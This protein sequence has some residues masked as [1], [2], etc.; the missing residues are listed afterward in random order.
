LGTA[1]VLSTVL[2]A[3]GA[4][5]AAAGSVRVRLVYAIEPGVE[6]C[7]GEA[8]LRRAIVDRVGYDPVDPTAATTLAVSVTRH[9]GR[10]LAEVKRV[11]EGGVVAGVRAIDAPEHG[12]E[13]LLQAV[14]LT[15]GI[16][17]DRIERETAAPLTEAI[18]GGAPDAPDAAPPPPADSPPGPVAESPSPD[19]ASPA[20]P[21]SKAPTFSVAAG[22]A[23][24]LGS[25]PAPAVGFNALA[26]ARWG[27]FDLG[28][29]GRM[30]LPASARAD[31]G[32][33][34]VSTS[35][36][37][38][39]PEG[40]FYLE[41]FFGCALVF[42]GDLHAEAVGVPGTRAQDGFDLLAGARAGV[43]L[44]MGAG[45]SLRASLD[46]LATLYGPTVRV[47]GQDAW[48][49][50]TGVGS[51]NFGVGWRIP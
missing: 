23:G 1:L 24:S 45:F 30:D 18:D 32:S 36:V 28:L 43:A 4:G 39:G 13:D 2:F 11:D 25:A 12:C 51:V 33:G 6:G 31:L 16:A 19:P 26:S 37:G 15:V 21:S 50:S 9:E 17:V 35:L 38:A 44:G 27:R 40:C 20:P 49:P 47:L 5:G 48:H 22:M 10:L 8:A 34:A 41:P 42:V 7:E 14:A 46:L 3:G 29:E